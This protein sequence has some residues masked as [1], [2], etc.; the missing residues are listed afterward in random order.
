MREV[1]VRRK[2]LVPA[3]DRL[4]RDQAIN[5]GQVYAFRETDVSK[6]GSLNVIGQSGM[7]DGERRSESLEQL[8]ELAF[9]PKAAQQLLHDDAGQ[10]DW[11]IG[12]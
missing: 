9:G 7:D 12:Q 5:A 2:E 8:V 6:T 1:A 10:T 3:C 4:G 11:N